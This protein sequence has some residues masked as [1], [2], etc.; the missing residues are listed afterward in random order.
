M[1]VPVHDHCAWH[2]QC[3]LKAQRR[4]RKNARA[5]AREEEGSDEPAPAGKAKA[6][7][8]PK[9][10]GKAKAKS[11]GKARVKPAAEASTGED[12]DNHDRHNDEDVNP[13]ALQLE[14]EEQEF[15][16]ALRAE[17]A[18]KKAKKGSSS[19]KAL[20]VNRTIDFD[21]HA[22]E[23]GGPSEVDARKGAGPK[24]GWWVGV[25][26]VMTVKSTC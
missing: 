13:E 14:A 17:P 2:V 11:K 10:K 16:A 1:S 15:K 26:S 6:K 7:A 22:S 21:E 20:P 25:S 24:A 18:V 23:D 12:L 8:K 5:E 3:I 4:L 9:G 19:S